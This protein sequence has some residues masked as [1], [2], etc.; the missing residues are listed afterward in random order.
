MSANSQ[1]DYSDVGCL[2]L[3]AVIVICVTIYKV[4]VL[5]A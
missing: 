4:A 3:L 1:P 2:A 5:F